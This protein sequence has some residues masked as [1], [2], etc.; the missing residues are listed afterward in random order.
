[1]DN[2]IRKNIG[3]RP[4]HLIEMVFSGVFTHDT[5][6]TFAILL[7]CSDDAQTYKI[8]ALFNLE[9]GKTEIKP[10]KSSQFLFTTS[11]NSRVSRS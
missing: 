1:M 4:K 8:V 7:C 9:G 5:R 11:E 2:F 10:Q 6:K 3:S